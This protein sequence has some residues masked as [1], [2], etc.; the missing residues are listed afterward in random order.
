[1]SRHGAKVGIDVTNLG[2]IKGASAVVVG[3]ATVSYRVF[4]IAPR[5]VFGTPTACV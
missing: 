3:N 5:V 1:V 2:D 4:P